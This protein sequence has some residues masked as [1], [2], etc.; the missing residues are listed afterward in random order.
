V[1]T[2]YF[3]IDSTSPTSLSL[4][5]SCPSSPIFKSSFNK[6][7][8]FLGGW[9]STSA[10]RGAPPLTARPWPVCL[11]SA[12]RSAAAMNG[13]MSFW[14]A[15]SSYVD[16]LVMVIR[17]ERRNLFRKLTSLTSSE[18]LRGTSAGRPLPLVWN[19]GI[20]QV[21][22]KQAINLQDEYKVV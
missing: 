2:L 22:G 12:S 21:L 13:M 7:S 5:F 16:V 1:F 19:S 6:A 11:V 4:P 17:N 20:V 14:T 3:R 18:R 8:S 15:S 10:V 9:C